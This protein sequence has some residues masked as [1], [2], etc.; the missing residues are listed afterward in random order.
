[1]QSQPKLIINIEK[2]QQYKTLFMFMIN[3]TL[4]QIWHAEMCGYELQL[5]K[6][7]KFFDI[8]ARAVVIQTGQNYALQMQ[9]IAR[10]A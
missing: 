10:C 6:K 2:R 9:K 1:M 7:K 8:Y 3:S 5:W 4:T